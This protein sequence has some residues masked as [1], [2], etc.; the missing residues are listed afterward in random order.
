MEVKTY[1]SEFLPL[2]GRGYGTDEPEC[3]ITIEL[4][5]VAIMINS[6]TD[7]LCG[8]TVSVRTRKILL[9]SEILCVVGEVYSTYD[10]WGIFH[11]SPYF[12]FYLFFYIM[13]YGMSAY[14]VKKKIYFLYGC[15]VLLALW[16]G[17]AEVMKIP[18]IDL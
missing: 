6:K 17:I 8:H 2:D 5:K 14:R 15:M 9:Y 18:F 11:M 12:W 13:G 16:T 1:I 7:N 10:G 4:G 3:R